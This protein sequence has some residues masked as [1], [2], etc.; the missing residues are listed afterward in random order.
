MHRL[1]SA[2]LA[3]AT[4]CL[5]L[6]PSIPAVL[7]PAI[8][9]TAIAQ[10]QETEGDQ[11][12]N[13]ALDH[14][15]SG[16]YQKA[17]APALQV[18]KMARETKNRELEGQAAL[19]LARSY[20]ELGKYQQAVEFAQQAQKIGRKLKNRDMEG[21]ATV[22]LA[23]AQRDSGKGIEFANQ[24]QTIAREIKNR[25]IEA[26]AIHVLANAHRGIGKNED[27]IQLAQQAIM[28]A[29]EIKNRE[30]EAW[31]ITGMA[32]SY[33]QLGNQQKALEFAQS[34]LINAREIKNP[35]IE[36][37]A[38]VVMALAY[39]GQGEYKK[40]IEF[41]LQADRIGR[42]LKNQQL[43]ADAMAMLVR[44][45]V[46]SEEYAKAIEPAQQ[47]VA[48]TRE[49][50]DK[51]FEANSLGWLVRAY[52]ES[53]KYA[54]AIELAQQLV[55]LA[56]ELKDK[57]SE[58]VAL[59][60]LVRA[61]VESEEYAKAIEP[62]QQLL[63]LTRELKNQQSE[64]N[65]LAW[66]VRAYV[67]SKEYTKAIEPAQQL[68][69]LTRE[70]K[71]KQ[72]E[73][74]ALAGLVRAYVES[75]EYA[76]AIA[77]AQQLLDS[78]RNSKQLENQVVALVW[79]ARAHAGQGNSPMA[80]GFVQQAEAISRSLKPVQAQLTALLL[81]QTTYDLIGDAKKAEE[82]A[83][84][85]SAL[86]SQTQ[87]SEMIREVEEKLFSYRLRQ[88]GNFANGIG[89]VLDLR[90]GL[91]NSPTLAPAA[92]KQL[93]AENG[94]F[95]GVYVLFSED[96]SKMENY[97]EQYWAAIRPTQDK[98]LELGALAIQAMVEWK[99]SE[100]KK[101]EATTD[102][103]LS[104]VRDRQ[105]SR[106]TVMGFWSA[107]LIFY[108]EAGNDQKTIEAT[109]TLLKFLSS[110]QPID[111]LVE[112]FSK[113]ILT[114][115][116]V[117]L[118]TSYARLNE[119]NKAIEL[120]KKNITSLDQALTEEKQLEQQNTLYTNKLATLNLLADSYRLLGQQEKAIQAYRESLELFL[121]TPKG[122]QKEYYIATSY[123]G[124]ARIYQQRNMPI[125]AITYYKQAVSTFEQSFIT[126]SQNLKIDGA[127]LSN[128][129]A[130][131][132]SGWLKQLTL[133]RGFFQDVARTKVVDMYRDLAD[134]LLSQGRILEAQ[135][136]LELLKTQEVQDFTRSNKTEAGA[137]VPQTPTEGRISSKSNSLIAFGQRVDECEQKT[138]AQLKQLLDQRDGLVQQFDSE[139]QAIEKEFRDRNIR[140]M[141]DAALAPKDFL[142]QAEEIVNAQPGTV[143]IY[144]LVMENRIWLLW[145]SRGGI[146]KREEVKGVGQKQLGETVLK[147]RQLLQNPN[148][149]LRELKATGKQLYDWLLQPMESELKA[150][151][152]RN[153]VFSLDR[154]SRYI[155]MSALFDGEKYLIERYT[156]STILSAGYTDMNQRPPLA[157]QN[158]QVMAFGLSAAKPGFNPLPNVP[159]ELDAIVRQNQQDPRGVY[160][161]AKF[162]NDRFTADTLRQNLRNYRVLHIATHGKFVPVNPDQSF[163]L[164]GDGNQ[165]E[166]PKIRT[167]QNLRNIDLVVLSACET[168]L[169][170]ADRDGV[171]IAGLSSYFLR[172]GAAK[173]VMASLW[174]VNDASTSLSMWQFYKNLATG[175]LT[176]AEALQKVQLSFLRGE[177]TAKDAP[178]RSNDAKDSS[179]RSDV[180][181]TSSSTRSPRP[182]NFSHPY[183]WAPFILIGNSL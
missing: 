2:G 69:A 166:I 106:W 163:L 90:L 48:L 96:L 158:T 107:S 85:V 141:D 103:F 71:D 100:P 154:S 78:A 132:L 13:I 38:L 114:N 61:Y 148:S 19:V 116:P 83:Q 37:Y 86:A 120:L 79:L 29:R 155:P 36:G 109:E 84:Q 1:K 135:Q 77:S 81:V 156:V 42:E 179:G 131:N 170:G 134:L 17:I 28:L 6:S 32:I 52:A 172:K 26:W 118:A 22:G 165:L 125:T 95:L 144:P 89:P 183:Y 74:I 151:N 54:N 46:E 119:H 176:K 150:N 73:T 75:K 24:A 91:K 9:Q 177:V 173:A 14:V 178:G 3:V 105:D 43:E 157:T 56:R 39:V 53:K 171:E 21:W 115:A 167:L 138:C 92:A 133:K 159:T 94:V 122:T 124:L 57:Q 113:S 110:N 64:A 145:A 40:T 164:L 168:A 50:K 49:L 41:A 161:G 93:W 67:E 65:A 80:N 152:V 33:S 162:L 160:P 12:L 27:S 153:L 108:P 147:F 97:L 181:V 102:L 127:N 35:T 130:S 128:L 104:K 44:A 66:L 5:C 98:D 30:I 63:A 142:G 101:L 31:A 20:V 140:N 34:N 146:V 47:L 60:V 123:A 62:A 72:S 59:S 68:L 8:A 15:Q 149:D 169:G 174:L 58:T 136:V 111:P 76:N 182:A 99:K 18:I 112:P 51:Q 23:S 82:L 25:E 55:A 143:L 11:L 7:S 129:A 117:S 137:E 70:L 10:N 175:E 121:Q 16:D 4:L 126:A 88:S 139:V 87:D 45:Y 180:M